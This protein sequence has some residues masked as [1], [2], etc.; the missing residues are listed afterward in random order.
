MRSPK[1]ES[2]SPCIRRRTSPPT[3][4]PACAWLPSCRAPMRGMPGAGRTRAWPAC[5]RAR[6]SAPPRCGEALSCAA[7]RPDLRVESLRGNVDTRLRKRSERGLDG[8]VLAACGLD[9]LGLV[10]EIGFRIEVEE[11]LPETGQGFLALQSRVRGC[12]GSRRRRR[13]AGRPHPGC[14]ARLR[15]AARGRLPGARRDACRRAA[16]RPA[17]AARLGRAARRLARRRG[18]GSRGRSRRTRRARSPEPRSS[19]EAR[20]SSPRCARDGLPRG[21]R[22]RATRA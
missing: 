20:R 2:T 22:S 8:V 15:S 3:R 6:A 7:L 4:R 9:R 11:M 17:L 10:H 13:R 5:R 14:G 16:G 19:A 21:C 1:G 12:P 18:G